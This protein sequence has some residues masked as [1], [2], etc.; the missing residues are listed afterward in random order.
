MKAQPS[1]LPGDVPACAS[2]FSSGACGR[3]SI[4]TRVPVKLFPWNSTSILKLE[5]NYFFI[6]L[7]AAELELELELELEQRQPKMAQTP[8]LRAVVYARALRAS[9][10]AKRAQIWVGARCA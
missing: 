5:M 6:F 9:R 1:A 4:L 2:G 10:I 8:V 7:K 3:K